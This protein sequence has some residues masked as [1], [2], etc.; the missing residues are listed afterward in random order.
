MELRGILNMILS[1]LVDDFHKVQIKENQGESLLI[2]EVTS[3]DPSCLGKIIGRGGRNALAIRT[4]MGAIGS[5]KGE[6]C[7]VNIMQY[8]RGTSQ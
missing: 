3:E 2:F 6:R 4:L 1:E 5:K 7:L 8:K